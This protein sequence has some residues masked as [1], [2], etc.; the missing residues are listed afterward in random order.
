[1]D[2]VAQGA[3]RRLGLTEIVDWMIE[4][5]CGIERIDRYDEWLSRFETAMHALPEEQRQESMLAILGPYRQPQRAVTQ[6]FLPAERFR[7]ATEA[8]GFAIPQLSAELIKKYVAD[9]RHLRLL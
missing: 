6:S 2:R 4:A 1:M 8:A 3:E 7:T 5:G 9:L